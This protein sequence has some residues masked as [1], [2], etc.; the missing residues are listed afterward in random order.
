M[1]VSVQ[2]GIE[3]WEQVVAIL[4]SYGLDVVG[5]IVTLIIGWIIAGRT[6][7][8]VRRLLGRI[9][10]IDHT[11]PGFFGSLARYVVLAVTI[12]AVLGQFGVETASLLAVFGAAGLAIGLALQGTLSNVAA[13]VMLLV[14]RPFKVGDYI[15]AGGLAGS[16]SAINL[17]VTELNTPDNVH[18]T[19]PNGQLWGSAVKNYSHHTTRRIDLVLGIAYE[20]DIDKAFAAIRAVI[21]AEPTTLKN[22]EPTIGRRRAGRQF[23]QFG[24]TRLVQC[25]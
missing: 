8:L 24:C 9:P 13:G 19:A 12:I 16:V 20:D 14:F 4:T 7:A 5:A 21:D 11:L 6:Q 1:Q 18:I 3:L 2:D 10:R 25:C 22:P 17:F 15:E 23:G